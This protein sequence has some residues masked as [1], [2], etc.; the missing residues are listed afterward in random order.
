MSS[1]FLRTRAW[2]TNAMLGAFDDAATLRHALAFESAL[3]LSAAEAG[4]LSLETAGAVAGACNGVD[5]D[6]AELADEAAFAGTLAIPLVTRLRLQLAGD[7]ESVAGVHLGA[8]SQDLIDTVMLL[9]A[10]DAADLINSDLKRIIRAL[11]RL[12]REHTGTPAPGRTLLQYAVPIAFGLRTAL[13]L[14]GIEDSRRKLKAACADGI[15]LQFGG[16]VGT[17]SGL[18]GRGEKVAQALARELGLRAPVAPWHTRRGNVAAI[19]AALG[20]AAGALG[21]MARD[22][23]LLAQN[24]VG[25]AHEP[26]VEGRGGSSAM[27]HK[28]NPTGSQVALSAAVRAPG[29]VSTALA[30]M[31]QEFERGVGGWQAEAPVLAELFML[32]GGSAD[33]IATVAEGLEINR[34]AAERNLAAAEIDGDLG[35]SR[36]IIE[37]LLAEY[38]MED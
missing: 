7:P 19:A 14:A 32:V 10:K 5:I 11:S 31:P 26:L 1:S 8:T 38:G 9:Q 4:L 34:V 27:P 36:I 6:P 16:A 29:L 21:K 37:A 15:E 20:I 12:T 30:G 24:A 28:R 22:I 2:T 3:A 13:W 17:R 25:E 35:E 23:S 33:A 18:Q